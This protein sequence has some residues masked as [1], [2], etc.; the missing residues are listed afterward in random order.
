MESNMTV[1]SVS[2]NQQLL[3]AQKDSKHI[4]I[5]YCCDECEREQTSNVF[6]KNPPKIR[7]N[8]DQ[9][10]YSVMQPM[11]SRILLSRFFAESHDNAL[12]EEVAQT[13]LPFQGI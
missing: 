4:G 10:N 3:R 12:R 2:T 7:Y 9:C 6:T 8:C 1:T 13:Q 11:Q 5:K